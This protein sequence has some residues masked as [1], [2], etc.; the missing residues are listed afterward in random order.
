[1]FC[2]IRL[3]TSGL[4]HHVQLLL[5]VDDSG[6]ISPQGVEFMIKCVE[7]VVRRGLRL[8]VQRG[9]SVSCSSLTCQELQGQ[10]VSSRGS[11]TVANPRKESVWMNDSLT[12][13]DDDESVNCQERVSM[14]E[15]LS[16][17]V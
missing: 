13:C 5:A 15:R 1:M 6:G 3:A 2:Y 17:I 4:L 11:E 10:T 12:S 9:T 16:D 7:C 14:N 8:R